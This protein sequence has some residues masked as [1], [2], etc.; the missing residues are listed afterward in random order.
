MGRSA[1]K[2]SS[3]GRYADSEV[4]SVSTLRR[5]TPRV[6]HADRRSVSTFR[7]AGI[8]DRIPFPGSRTPADIRA[9]ILVCVRS[10]GQ[11]WVRT[12]RTARFATTTPPPMSGQID[13]RPV[14]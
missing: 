3:I 6:T 10:D 1:G 8:G 2:T 4:E 14:G 7:L 11:V 9:G 12:I 5:A 13:G